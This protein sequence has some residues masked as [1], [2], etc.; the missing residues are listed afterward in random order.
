[1]LKNLLQQNKAQ[2]E[3]MFTAKHP[4]ITMLKVAVYRNNASS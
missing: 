1:M 2:Q 4:V 3:T